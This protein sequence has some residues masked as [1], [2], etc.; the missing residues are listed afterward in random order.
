[1]LPQ[2]GTSDTRSR[3]RGNSNQNKTSNRLTVEY[4]QQ[5]GAS[6]KESLPAKILMVKAEEN[7]FQSGAV[8]VICK[9][10]INGEIRFWYLD[11]KK[12]PNYGLLTKKFGHDENEWIDK[13]I[14]LGLEQND[15]YE[16]QLIRVSFP[17]KK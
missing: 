7:K 9:V 5:N 8:Q 16:N 10:A 2:S 12:N 14:L 6:L 1:M 3:G 4:L 11:I 13:Q 17:T 15:F